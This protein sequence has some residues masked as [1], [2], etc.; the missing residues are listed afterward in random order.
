MNQWKKLKRDKS[1]FL[2]CD[3]SDLYDY[4]PFLLLEDCSMF[5]MDDQVYIVTQEGFYEWAVDIDTKPKFTHIMPNV[6]L[7]KRN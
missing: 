4:T 5:G 7:I 2:T 6:E 3:V 1:G